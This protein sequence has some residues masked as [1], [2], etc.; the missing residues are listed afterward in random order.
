M[1]EQTTNTGNISILPK[2]YLLRIDSTPK[3]FLKETGHVKNE[4]AKSSMS[5][6]KKAK[7]WNQNC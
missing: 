4:Y 6:L 1:Q 7:E 2:T 5:R 3:Y